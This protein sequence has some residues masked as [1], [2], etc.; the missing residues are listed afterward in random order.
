[1]KSRISVAGILLFFTIW[2]GGLCTNAQ[3]TYSD[4]PLPIRGKENTLWGVYIKDLRTGRVIDNV[5]GE[6]AFVPASVTKALTCASVLSQIPDDY[7]F[8]TEFKISGDIKDGTLY[9]NIIVK[10]SGDPTIESAYFKNYNG[11]T[12]SVA[13]RLSVRGVSKIEGSVIFEYPYKLEDGIPS[14]WMGEDLVW[15]YGTGHHAVNYADNRINLNFSTGSS[16]PPTT[17][18]DI[19]REKGVSLKRL[20]DSK[21]IV[22]PSGLKGTQQIAAPDPEDVF[23][24]SLLKS[25]E[26]KGISFEQLKV[27]IKD[28]TSS[29]YGYVSPSYAQIMK[30][31]MWR[32]DNMM[33]EAMLRTLAPERWRK[34]AVSRE[35]S[36]WDARGLDVSKIYVEDGS[37]LSRK[38]RITPKF[39][40]EVLEWMAKSD[41][42]ELFISFFPRAGKEGTMR[43][44]MKGSALEGVMATKTGSMRGVQCYAGYILDNNNKPTHVITLMANGFTADR[45][46]LKQA[47]GQYV[48]DKLGLNR[49]INDED[50]LE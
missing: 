4:C 17:K 41:D 49:D 38:N 35:I 13:A 6:M 22:A 30:S 39:L 40:C 36:L 50:K 18:L 10:C 44:F 31:L 7:V 25:F 46:A 11:V 42:A 34:D 47:I 28:V 14:G 26:N 9:G 16:V 5:N 3:M 43:N 32:S 21:T 19:R 8:R 24:A 33:A 37:G 1:M 20:R 27:P 45:G 15:P 23:Y 12:D 48:I 29:L 2:V